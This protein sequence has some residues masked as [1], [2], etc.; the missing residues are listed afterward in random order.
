[1]GNITCWKLA[2]TPDQKIHALYNS[3]YASEDGGVT[4]ENRHPQFG[5]IGPMTIHGNDVYV[6]YLGSDKIYRSTNAGIDWTQ[7]DTTGLNGATFDNSAENQIALDA[8]GYIYAYCRVFGNPDLTGV[9]RSTQPISGIEKET[10]ILPKEFTLY[11]NYPNPFNPSTTIKFSVPFRTNVSIKIYDLLGVEIKTLIKDEFV[12]GIYNVEFDAG[13][14]TSGIYFYI[15]TAGN[16]RETKKMIL[17][18]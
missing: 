12:Q 1:K 7:L 11:Q 4:W 17:L 8:Q 15:I 5:L 10:N 3:Y 13:N 2:V 16:F 6:G 18:K 9:Y 14:I